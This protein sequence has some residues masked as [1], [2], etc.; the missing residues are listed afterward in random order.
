MT[1]ADAATFQIAQGL[2]GILFVV[3]LVV[4]AVLYR[5]RLRQIKRLTE[6]NG[7]LAQQLAATTARL[8][9]IERWR[10]MPPRT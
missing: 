8:E 3:L 10:G 2:G 6:T 4:V 9:E 7:M 1:D 5:R